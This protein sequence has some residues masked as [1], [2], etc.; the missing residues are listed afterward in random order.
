MASDVGLRTTRLISR[1]R[2]HL[3]WKGRNILLLA[4]CAALQV[5]FA[6]FCMILL[7]RH[8]HERG[9][10]A[11]QL[12]TVLCQ[13]LE[14][15]GIF[16]GF[17]VVAILVAGMFIASA[18]VFVVGIVEVVRRAREWETILM[19]WERRSDGIANRAQVSTRESPTER[20]A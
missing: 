1:A 14:P 3:R 5:A 7:V 20:R 18:L 6:V 15:T 19:L 4:M 13:P 2:W 8:L 9:V 16:P 17:V 11:G 10:P 12:F